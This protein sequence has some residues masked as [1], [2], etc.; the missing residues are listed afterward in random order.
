MDPRT[1]ERFVSFGS[2]GLDCSCLPLTV[3]DDAQRDE[4]H[5]FFVV[6]PESG[7]LLVENVSDRA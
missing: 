1:F 4:H 6:W 3:N 5:I 2:V 7:S